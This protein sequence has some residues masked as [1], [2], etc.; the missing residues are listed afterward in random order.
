[1]THPRILVRQESLYPIGLFV[2]DAAQALG[3]NRQTLSNLM[4]GRSGITPEMALR[5]EKAFGT[6][7]RFWMGRQVNHE[8]ETVI[9]RAHEIEVQP[10]TRQTL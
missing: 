3:C 10:F 8:L 2:T 6:S 9:A 5:L 7:A 4:D 1:M